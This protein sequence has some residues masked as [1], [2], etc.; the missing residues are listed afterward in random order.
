M[1]LPP[2]VTQQQIDRAAGFYPD[3]EEQAD[4]DADKADHA[5]DKE[6]ERDE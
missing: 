2:G 3:P 6:N 4:I 5:R 1:N